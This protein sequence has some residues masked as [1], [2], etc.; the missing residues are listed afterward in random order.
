[1]DLADMLTYTD[2]GQ[3]SRIANH[4]QCECSGHSKHELI[5]SI[6]Q[7]VSR[8]DFIDRHVSEMS[9]EDLRFLNTLLFDGRRQ[10]S[11]EE[12]VACAQAARFTEDAKERESPRDMITRFRQ[13]GWLFNGTTHHTRY[14]FEIP[15]D[16][17]RRFREVLEQRFV[18]GIQAAPE[19]LMYREEPDMLAADLLLLLQYVAGRDIPLNGEGVMYRR[20]QLQLME[21][22]HVSESLIGKGWRFG[23]GRRFRDYPNRMALLYDYAHHCRWIRENADALELTEAGREYLTEQ[24]QEPMMQFVR[25]WLRI[26]KGP[27]PN[28]LSLIYWILCCSKDWVTLSSLY[29][30]VECLIKPFF[31]D[32]PTSIFEERLIQMMLHLGIV[33]VGEDQQRERYVQATPFGQTVIAELG[34]S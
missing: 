24:R 28:L 30:R 14:L 18:S 9:P 5:Q 11:L 7:T 3:L 23:Y 32:T 2:I 31:Y 15:E 26:Y 1:M 27:I 16:L 19:P 8:R 34:L 25:F 12:L 13:R 20:N 10:F 22:L 4:Y 33:R 21:T 6:L 17:K 29:E